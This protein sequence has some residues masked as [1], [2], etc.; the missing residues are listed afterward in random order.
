MFNR[1]AKVIRAG[2]ICGV[3]LNGAFPMV[4]RREMYFHV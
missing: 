3:G 1:F 4:N 2:V